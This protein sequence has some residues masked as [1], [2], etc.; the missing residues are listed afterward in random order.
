MLSKAFAA[1][2][3]A[4][5]VSGG[6]RHYLVFDVKTQQLELGLWVDS[7]L[8]TLV[9]DEDE[10]KYPDILVADIR[11]LFEKHGR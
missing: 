4:Y 3:E 7:E 1:L 2:H 11:A 10:L 9:F 8:H 6:R 5:P